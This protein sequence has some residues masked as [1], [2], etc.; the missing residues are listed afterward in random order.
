MA[1]MVRRAWR[2]R[3]PP[4]NARR[5]LGR[6]DGRAAAVEVLRRFAYSSGGMRST[7]PG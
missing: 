1:L 2:G 4:E 6:P 3:R 5:V 7:W